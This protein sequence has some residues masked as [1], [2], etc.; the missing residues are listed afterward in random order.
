MIATQ[1]SVRFQEQGPAL[2]EA[3]IDTKFAKIS[4]PLTIAVYIGIQFETGPRT[5]E[6][7]SVVNIRQDQLIS[8]A[9]NCCGMKCVRLPLQCDPNIAG[10]RVVSEQFAQ[11]WLAGWSSQFEL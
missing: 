11:L 7:L 9:G 10:Q 4:D 2:L 6:F 3:A 8:I 1:D 5:D